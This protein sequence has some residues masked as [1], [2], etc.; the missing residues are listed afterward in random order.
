MNEP[1]IVYC[2]RCNAVVDDGNIYETADADYICI[3]C[4]TS[5]PEP[6]DDS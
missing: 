5:Y 1:C 4:Y 3:D 6:N 2:D